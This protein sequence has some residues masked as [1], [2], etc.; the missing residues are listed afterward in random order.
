MSAVGGTSD[1]T[2][3]SDGADGENG[4]G[5]KRQATSVEGES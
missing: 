5:E 1:V 4:S 3:M 2:G